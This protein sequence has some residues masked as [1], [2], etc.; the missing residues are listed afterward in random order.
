MGR[1]PNSCPPPPP[2]PVSAAPQFYERVVIKRERV[3]AAG[4]AVGPRAGQHTTT[5]APLHQTQVN[6]K[7]KLVGV[8]NE[9]VAIVNNCRCKCL[10]DT[11]SQITTLSK[12]FYES[13][14]PNV[15]LRSIDDFLRIEG[16]NGQPVPYLGYVEVSIRLPGSLPQPFDVDAPVLIV[17]DTPYN[18]KVP[19]CVGTNVIQ[20]CVDRGVSLFGEDFVTNKQTDPTWQ[21]VYKCMQV[22]VGV[23]PKG[24]IGVIRSAAKRAARIPPKQ[25]VIVDREAP[26]PPSGRAYDVIVEP[27]TPNRLPDGIVVD[28]NVKLIRITKENQKS[29]RIPVLVQNRT[30]S[31]IWIYRNMILGELYLCDVQGPVN[32]NSQSV[33]DHDVGTGSKEGVVEGLDFSDSPASPEDV[34]QVTRVIGNYPHAFSQSDTDLGHSNIIEHTIPLTDPQPFRERYRRIPLSM[35]AE[36][37]EHLKTMHEANVIRESF[38]PVLLVRTK[39]GS[40]RFCIDFRKLNQRTIRDSYALPRIDETLQMMQGAKWFSS[41]DLKSGHWQ[42]EIAEK[43]KSKTAFVMPPPLGLWECNRMPFGL[44][45]APST[46]QRTMEKCLGDLNNMCCVVYLDEIIVFGKTVEEHVSRLEAVIQRLSEHGF[47]LKASK[48]KLLQNRVKYRRRNRNRPRQNR[49]HSY[50]ARP[51]WA[52][53]VTT[54]N[55]FLTCPKL[56]VRCVNCLGIQNVEKG[57][58]TPPPL[59]HPPPHWVWGKRQ[60]D[61]F[62][63]I[64]DCLISPPPPPPRTPICR[65]LQTFYSA[66][67][68][69]HARFRCSAISTRWGRRER[70]VAYDSRSLNSSEP[71][72]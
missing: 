62:Q 44:C 37:R 26:L 67:G 71:S 23:N 31:P 16:A 20:I 58:Q 51:F 43:D 22:P 12:S 7:F 17:Y 30:E 59:F 9:T 35:Y 21:V 56:R 47:K 63:E 28:Q 69:E 13:H 5:Q 55:S 39:D 1:L 49:I 48:C 34:E 53:Q 41:L 66:Y 8:A 6:I 10:L 70:V 52:W 4:R 29:R 61:A 38:L 45:N 57:N 11:G 24:K 32:A 19:L 2:P 36:V 33:H 27:R 60:S 25:A 65:F 64:K 50:L 54:G 18:K 14:F 42:L 68:C 15:P 72:A 3:S 46:F 40:L